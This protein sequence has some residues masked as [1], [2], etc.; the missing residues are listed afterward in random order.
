VLTD[1]VRDQAF[2][3]AWFGL[4]A[5]V[6]FGWAQEDPPP[7]WRW[8]LGVG[9]VVGL[10]F[11]ALFGSIA[12]RNWS[13]PSALDGRYWWFGLLVLV[14]F[15]VAGAGCLVL[16]RRGQARWMAWWVALVVALHFLPLAWFLNDASSAALGVLQVVLLA[17]LFRR[18]RNSTET[19]SR[20]V[21]VMMGETLLAFAFLSA[22][23]FY[24]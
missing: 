9:S 20:A 8:R 18:L 23:E 14:E 15:I 12:A 22:I 13:T 11:A 16:A 21:G 6:W 10:G 7:S 1:L 24:L 5:V 2:T 19:T 4:M 17:V 3:I